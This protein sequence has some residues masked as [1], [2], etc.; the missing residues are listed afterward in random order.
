M[1]FSL[2]WAKIAAL[3]SA[4]HETV[5]VFC[6][7]C[8]ASE[9][10]DIAHVHAPFT[11]DN[12]CTKCTGKFRAYIDPNGCVETEPFFS[13]KKP[14]TKRLSPAEIEARVTKKHPE[15][16]VKNWTVRVST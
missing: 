12:V 15:Y 8:F 11:V 13:R 4:R 5:T 7:H 6:P 10:K 3:F 14:R 2:L 9:E 16:T 1:N